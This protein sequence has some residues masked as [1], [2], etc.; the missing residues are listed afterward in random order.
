MQGLPY[1]MGMTLHLQPAAPSWESMG[2]CP[3]A[4]TLQ[5]TPV[6]RVFSTGGFLGAD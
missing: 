3:P 4:Q 5:S 6:R 2:L 1:L